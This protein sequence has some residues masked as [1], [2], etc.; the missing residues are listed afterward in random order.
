VVALF[1]PTDPVRN[2][3]YGG[4]SIVLRHARSATSYSHT[5][6][7]DDGLSLISS[8]EVISAVHRLVG[9]KA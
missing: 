9:I 6:R 4:R 3:P 7:T 1:G 2:G 8:A 5:A